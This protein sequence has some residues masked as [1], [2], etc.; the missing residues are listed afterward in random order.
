[1]EINAA[2]VWEAFREKAQRGEIPPHTL[3]AM[4]IYRAPKDA[5]GLNARIDVSKKYDRSQLPMPLRAFAPSEERFLSSTIYEVRNLVDGEEEET[6]DTLEE[7]VAYFKQNDI[8]K[9]NLPSEKAF[10]LEEIDGSLYLSR[11]LS[12]Q[13]SEEMR[14]LAEKLK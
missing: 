5:Q 8:G 10:E 2:D 9:I 12:E 4:D 11:G 7:A 3:Y 13:E 6:F 14:T 1:M